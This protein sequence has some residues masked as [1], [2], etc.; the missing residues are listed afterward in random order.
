M[1]VPQDSQTIALDTGQQVGLATYGAEDGFPIL[2]L[3]GAPACRLMFD[4]A[5]GSARRSGFKLYC[6]DRP[7][8]GQ[9]PSLEP[10]TLAARV[11]FLASVVDTLG[12]KRF[13]VLGISGGG[14]YATALAAHFGDRIAVLGL[15]SP[16]GPI[17]DFNATS[18]PKGPTL[19]KGHRIF[20]L[21]LP[22]YPKILKANSALIRRLFL[23][24]PRLFA[25]M[26]AKTLPRIDRDDLAAPRVAESVIAMTKEALRQGV[27]G[28]LAD[29]QIYSE[30][31]AVDYERITA[32]TLVWQGT[33]DRIVPAVAATYLSQQIR[34]ARLIRLP[35]AGHFWVYSHIDE[36]F[37]GLRHAIQD[38]TKY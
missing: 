15:V 36:M 5:D 11:N 33:S 35:D 4:V 29:L 23:I 31:W 32:P 18:M 24:A 25:A 8:Y 13:G 16:V 28:G 21:D 9:T 26:F 19:Q 1:M 38:M 10:V 14:P 17:A 30:S 37:A 27:D 12:L 22:K 7:G 2:A 34:N 3:H 20:F 6:P